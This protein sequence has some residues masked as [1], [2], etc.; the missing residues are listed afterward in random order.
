[1]GAPAFV[2]SPYPV[3]EPRPTLAFILS[4]LGGIFIALGGATEFYFALVVYDQGLSSIF[5]P[6][7]V[8]LGIVGLGL[9]IITVLFSVALY[10]QPQHHVLWGVLIIVTSVASVVSYAGFLVGLVLGL[11]GGVIAIVWVPHPWSMAPYG[12]GLSAG[13]PYVPPPGPATVALPQRACLRC[14]RLI[15]YDFKFC[16]HC[17]TAVPG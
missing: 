4:M 9:G 3:L 7:I 6:W 5:D 8:E 15:G 10:N 2:A 13:W 12:F 11:I 14:G 16:P 17:G 1:M